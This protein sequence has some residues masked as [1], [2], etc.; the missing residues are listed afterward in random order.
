[1]FG[2]A[3]VTTERV[4]RCSELANMSTVSWLHHICR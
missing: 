3:A 4:K 2:C 1:M